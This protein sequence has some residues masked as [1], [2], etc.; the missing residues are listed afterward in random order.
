MKIEC[1]KCHGYHASALCPYRAER[2]VTV[3]DD[4]PRELTMEEILNL[5]ER[6][7]SD[8]VEQLL[9]HCQYCGTCMGYKLRK[10]G[11]EINCSPECEEKSSK[12][13][14][15]QLPCGHTFDD[16]Y[17]CKYTEPEGECTA[18]EAQ[19]AKEEFGLDL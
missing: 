12:F 11:E 16:L 14:A 1:Q 2:E 3:V 13:L 10:M 9:T 15:R 17:T 5:E 8:R 7:S 6:Y 18:C 19:W 4:A